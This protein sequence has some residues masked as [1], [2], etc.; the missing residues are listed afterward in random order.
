MH[1]RLRA[2]AAFAVTLVAACAAP[3]RASFSVFATSSAFG[4]TGGTDTK[5]ENSSKSGLRTE[6]ENAVG[7][8]GYAEISFDFAGGII[9]GR[10]HACVGP[11]YPTTTQDSARGECK[12]FTPIAE[13]FTVTSDTLPLGTVVTVTFCADM[14]SQI[15]GRVM[16]TSGTGGQSGTAMQFQA[17]GTRIQATHGTDNRWTDLEGTNEFNGQDTEFATAHVVRTVTARVGD[18]FPVFVQVSSLTLAGATASPGIFPIADGSAGFAMTFGLESITE[19]ARLTWNGADWAG[20][21][22]PSLPLIPDNPVPAPATAL[23]LCAAAVAPCARRR[24]RR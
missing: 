9:T 1:R 21:C 23:L 16:P 22:D 12:A 5:N 2:S 8:H 3:S 20:S 11:S 13:T 19:G 18:T 17:L 4:P 10:N 24:R 7:G 14:S 6:K 15:K